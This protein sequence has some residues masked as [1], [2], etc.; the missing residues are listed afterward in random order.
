[1]KQHSLTL[2]ED[3]IA[4]LRAALDSHAYW[5]LSDEHYRNDGC[6]NEPGSDDPDAAQDIAAV[7]ALDLYLAAL[8]TTEQDRREGRRIPDTPAR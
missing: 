5:Q 4:L 7:N 6:V 2:T 8:L 3:E 1:M